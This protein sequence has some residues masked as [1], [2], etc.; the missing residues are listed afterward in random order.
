M[1]ILVHFSSLILKTSMFTLAISCL[2]TSNLPWFMGLT[3]QVPMQ[4]CSLQNWALLSPPDTPTARHCFH[5]GSGS[6]FFLE[7]FLHSSPVA[8]WTPTY[9][10]VHL[11]VSYL[12][13]FSYC[14]QVRNSK[15]RILKVRILKWFAIPFS[16]GRCFVRILH[17]DTSIFGGPTWHGSWFHWVRQGCGSSN[18]FG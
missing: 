1:P 15:V 12:F 13:P 11:S 8:Y 2:I 14:S 10:R 5:F 18:Q 3:F 16:R 6:S 9:L 4:Y 7:L 17:H